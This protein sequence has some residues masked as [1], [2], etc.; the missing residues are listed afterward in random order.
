MGH[1]FYLVTVRGRRSQGHAVFVPAKLPEAALTKKRM[2]ED[3]TDEEGEG[4]TEQKP[5]CQH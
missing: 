3:E 5:F 2:S 1:V 4:E